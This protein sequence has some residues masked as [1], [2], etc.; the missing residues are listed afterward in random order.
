MNE[1]RILRLF[2]GTQWIIHL[3][4]TM[5]APNMTHGRYRSERSPSNEKEFWLLLQRWLLEL[6]DTNPIPKAFSYANCA[7]VFHSP[8]F[9]LVW[10]TQTQKLYMCGRINSFSS[11]FPH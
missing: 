7:E 8:F 1:F 11:S 4:E 3:I 9:L 10:Q 2:L 5:I 6:V